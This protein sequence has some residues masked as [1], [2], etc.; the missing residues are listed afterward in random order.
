[1]GAC[2]PLIACERGGGFYGFGG[3]GGGRCLKVVFKS[4]VPSHSSLIHGFGG[5]FDIS[6]HFTYNT[7]IMEGCPSG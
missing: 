4:P 2:R 7:I 5:S 6:L 3:F 1:M